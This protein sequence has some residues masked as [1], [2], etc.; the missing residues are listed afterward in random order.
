MNELQL[1]LIDSVE[2][3][4]STSGNF[5]CTY[6]ANYP[7]NTCTYTGNEDQLQIILNLPGLR[8]S[9]LRNATLLLS[10]IYVVVCILKTNLLQSGI[11]HAVL[12][13]VIKMHAYKMS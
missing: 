3:K 4:T 12:Y 2:T 13:C 10:F 9:N 1:P 5:I 8:C 6:F 7:D 11:M